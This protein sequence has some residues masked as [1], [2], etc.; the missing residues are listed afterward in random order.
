MNDQEALDAFRV[1]LLKLCNNEGLDWD[2]IQELESNH[3]ELLGPLITD[4]Q[5]LF[6]GLYPDDRIGE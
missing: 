5:K 1:Q 3:F 6:L 4:I 2:I